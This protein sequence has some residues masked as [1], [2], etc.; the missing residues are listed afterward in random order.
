MSGTELTENELIEERIDLSRA[1]CPNREQRANGINVLVW[2]G[3]RPCKRSPFRLPEAKRTEFS[4][5]KWL[6]SE[7]LSFSKDRNNS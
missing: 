7:L 5:V 6:C 1:T 3:K 2:K 4:A